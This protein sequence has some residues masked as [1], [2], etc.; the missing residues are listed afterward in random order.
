MNPCFVHS[1]DR[2]TWTGNFASRRDALA[3]GLKAARVQND[4]VGSVYVAQQVQPSAHA[5]GHA[6]MLLAEMNRRATE[7][8]GTAAEGFVRNV[9]EKLVNELNAELE[10]VVL[11]WIDR[12]HLTL[13]AVEV[14]AISEHPVPATANVRQDRLDEV[15]DALGN[16]APA[17]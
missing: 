2:E 4:S 14:E 8:L 13:N 16:E 3:A 6:Q 17:V 5:F 12:H 1:L 7:D 11:A 10:K 9:P 15:D